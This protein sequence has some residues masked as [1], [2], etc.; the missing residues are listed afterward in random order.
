MKFGKNTDETL[1]TLV[2][3]HR[4]VDF[5]SFFFVG[6]QIYNTTFSDLGKK[7]YLFPHG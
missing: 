2:R 7:S 6:T 5:T 4:K 1:F 3:A